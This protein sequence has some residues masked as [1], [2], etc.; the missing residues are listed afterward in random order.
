M[1]RKRPSLRRRDFIKSAGGAAGIG[2]I[3]GCSGSGGG[4]GGGGGSEGPVRVGVIAPMD[5]PV[6]KNIRTG[7]QV[8]V[9]EVN[10]NGGVNGSDLELVV[11]NNGYDTQKTV[12][13]YQELTAGDPVSMTMGPYVSENQL[14]IMENIAQTGILH[15]N[16]ASGTPETTRLLAK[17]F[18]KYKYYFRVGPLNGHYR[19]REQVEFAKNNFQNMG[20]ERVAV[21][22]EDY[23]WTKPI[24]AVLNKHL[25]DATDA[26]I[27]MNKR[28]SGDTNDFSPLFDQAAS[29]NA[30][31]ILTAI[32]HIG[33]DFIV[34][35]SDQERPFGMA[36]VTVPAEDPTYYQNTNGKCAYVSGSCFGGVQNGYVTQK[37]VE[38]AKAYN[39]AGGYGGAPMYPAFHAF[40][41]IKMFA[42]AANEA[43]SVNSDDLI[44]VLEQMSHQG[45]AGTIEFYP[46]DH[47]YPHDVKYGQDLLHEMQYQWQEE[48]GAG[49]Q[50]P[51]APSS[52]A[53]NGQYET[54]DWIKS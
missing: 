35:W 24:S 23:A 45:T 9:D 32:A 10:S 43:S 37:G 7:A 42:K 39:E 20:W 31:G 2:M 36:G 21:L 54:P 19:G 33:T 26:T 34:Q 1:V 30:D 16:V 8:A 13:R 49:V 18:E 15:M 3:A 44:P 38:F 50:V 14:T 17:N 28:F 6:G 40:D 11:K 52:V 12:S 53:K 25:K 41:A 46:K 5:A 51:I 22:V 48:S 29:K 47:Q 4:G 27:V